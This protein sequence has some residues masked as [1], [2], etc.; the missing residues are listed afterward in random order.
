MSEKRFYGP[1]GGG[2]GGGVG[3]GNLA[4][5]NLVPMPLLGFLPAATQNGPKLR[6]WERH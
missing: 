1:S 6:P 3:P 2:G 4:D 5:P